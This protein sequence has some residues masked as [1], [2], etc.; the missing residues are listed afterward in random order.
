MSV[1]ISRLIVRRT[2][3]TCNNSKVTNRTNLFG[4]VPATIDVNVFSK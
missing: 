3:S 2:A 1:F 4:L